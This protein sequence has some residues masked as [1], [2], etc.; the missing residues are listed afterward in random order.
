MA[1]MLRKKRKSTAKVLTEPVWYEL[2]EWFYSHKED[3][4][5][6][7]SLICD[8]IEKILRDRNKW[9][10]GDKIKKE[11]YTGLIDACRRH[12]IQLYKL[13][14]KNIRQTKSVE[15]GYKI[16]TD[17]EATHFLEQR[18]RRFGLAGRLVVE[19]IPLGKKQYLSRPIKEIWSDTLDGIRQVKDTSERY[20]SAYDQA[21]AQRKSAEKEVRKIESK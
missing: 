8:R 3:E 18:I 1:M 12:M 11:M 10:K 4:I 2:S 17:A 13:T 15:G 16:A 5:L 9:T 14:L 7:H 19:M 21:E 20:L 6:S